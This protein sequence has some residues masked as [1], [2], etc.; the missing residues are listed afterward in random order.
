MTAIAPMGHDRLPGKD[1]SGRTD[2]PNFYLSSGGT[3]IRLVDS[4]YAFA[5]AR[6]LEPSVP[7][8]LPDSWERR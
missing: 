8:K 2:E 5:N 4:D 3:R 6:T 1:F 7:E